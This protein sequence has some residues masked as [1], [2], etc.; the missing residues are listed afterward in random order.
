MATTKD[1]ADAKTAAKDESKD[2]TTTTEAEK[3][4]VPIEP[5]TVETD[6]DKAGDGEYAGAVVYG[7]SGFENPEAL[8]PDEDA[9]V[10]GTTRVGTQEVPWAYITP[11]H[12]EDVS[13]VRTSD[14][15]D[16]AKSWTVQD[17]DG[18]GDDAV[19]VALVPEVREPGQTFE[20]S[21]LPNADA[22][23][24]AGIDPVQFYSGLPV[25]TAVHD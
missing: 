24:N 23:E 25:R 9:A 21:E 14:S 20:V 16:P 11:E 8:E 7:D 22:M 6:K 3:Q 10:G 1:K 5:Q 19:A 13:E 2:V 15:D 4:K 12:F 18:D 17:R